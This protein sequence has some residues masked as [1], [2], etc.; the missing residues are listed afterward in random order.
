MAPKEAFLLLFTHGVPILF[1]TYM[2]TNVLLRNTKKTEHILI[3]IISVCYLLLF[4]E[5]YIRQ[6]LPIEYSPILSSLWLSSIGLL[7]PGLG[8]HFLVKFTS[9]NT[10]LPRFIYPYIFYLP[11]IVIFVNFVTGADLFSAQEY[12]QSGFWK[13]PVYNTGYYITMTASIAVNALFLIP[14]L[15][16]RARAATQEQKSIYLQLTF[17]GSISVLWNIVF[18]YFNYGDSL[19]PYPY[20]YSGIIWCYFLRH[21]MK[22]YDFLTLYDKRYEK[23]FN[24]NPDAILLIDS[25]NNIKNLNPG[26]KRLFTQL[27]LEFTH[28]YELLDTETRSLMQAGVVMK[29]YETE[30]LHQSKP[31]FLLIH[32]DYVWIDNERHILLIV[33]DITE[34]REQQ[35]EVKFLAYHDPLTRLPN[36]RYFHENLDAALQEAERSNEMLALLLID[37]DKIKLLNDT[38]GHL[39]GDEAL[40]YA[41]L[42]LRETVGNSGIAARMGGDEFILFIR[43]PASIQEI[44]LKIQHMQDK[45]AGYMTKYGKLPIGMSIGVS[46]FP[47]DAS[48]GQALINIA[49]NAMYE[50]KRSRASSSSAN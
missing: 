19:P 2:A 21:T 42:I 1:F 28:F 18:G 41:A 47:I 8:F 49:D 39:A 35:E 43:N 11:L 17:G 16:A 9:L 10:R 24:L 25:N 44:E 34:Q 45:F 5:E 27:Q 33:R 40:Q 22:R 3:S 13:L 15:I 29:H 23:L 32:A 12:V 36:R 7:L 6:Q 14:L 37:L 26:A 48:D 50:M 31:L 4:A 46:Y 30:I 20:L 38:R